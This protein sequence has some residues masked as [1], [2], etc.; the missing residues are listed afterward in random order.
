MTE[1]KLPFTREGFAF[2]QMGVRLCQCDILYRYQL[3]W[4]ELSAGTK[5]IGDGTA[6][7]NRLW[8]ASD[9]LRLSEVAL[10][11]EVS[12]RILEFLS[13]VSIEER[14]ARNQVAEG[15]QALQ[16]LSDLCDFVECC[17]QFNTKHPQTSQ[18][19]RIGRLIAAVHDTANGPV[20][21]NEQQLGYLLADLNLEMTQLLAEFAVGTSPIQAALPSDR[22]VW[23]QIE[24]GLLRARHQLM[25]IFVD[26]KRLSAMVRDVPF[27]LKNESVA[28]FL[29]SLV[30]ADGQWR[31]SREIIAE[32]DEKL[33][34][35][36]VSRLRQA[37]HPEIQK[38]IHF[39]DPRGY[40]LNLKS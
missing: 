4:I 16:V 17:S 35:V 7:A 11:R 9:Q 31:N 20:W 34:G 29:Q 6:A 18:W 27:G 8:G 15:S 10:S 1:V 40:R 13:R 38:L 12:E 22:K 33:V 23:H 2:Y 30:N 14:H 37:L 26:V 19:F 25:P 39:D 36:K 21:D 3:G 28:Y 32:H 24:E 5:W